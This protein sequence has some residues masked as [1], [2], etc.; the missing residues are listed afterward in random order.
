MNE[1]VHLSHLYGNLDE[2]VQAGG[3]NVSVKTPD[4]MIIKASGYNLSDV[5]ES[6]GFVK[7]DN[8]AIND[9]NDLS[10]LV[11]DSYIINNINNLV[12]SIE[13]YFHLFLSKYTVHL[14]PTLV[15]IYLCSNKQMP[16]LDH[17][18][19][20]INYAKPGIELANHIYNKYNKE[21]IVFLRNHGVI[22]TSDDI[23]E[24]KLIINNTYYKFLLAYENDY[25]FT[26]LYD[27][28][29]LFD[30]YPGKVVYRIPQVYQHELQAP[31]VSYTPDIGIYLLNTVVRHKGIMYLVANTKYKCLQIL[32]VINSYIMLK[33]NGSDQVL[34][35]NDMN[36]LIGWNREQYRL[37]LK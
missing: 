31:I 1:F 21:P 6:D 18:H 10:M 8:G 5:T 4:Y 17:K 13:T 27:Y 29:K 36:Q 25:L 9:Y 14:H 12:P 7:L 30:K 37:N 15:N 35:A 16:I 32:E 3:G 20:M 2:L 33:Q 11:L 34:G 24:L 19:I 22:F 26:N 23:N 28:S